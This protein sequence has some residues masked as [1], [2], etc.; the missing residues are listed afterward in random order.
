M[1]SQSKRA[2]G[3]RLLLV[4]CLQGWGRQSTEGTRVRDASSCYRHY[5][6]GSVLAAGGQG[7]MAGR[8]EICRNHPHC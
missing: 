2:K 4:K 3:V 7:L 8:W 5:E 1:F 6:D